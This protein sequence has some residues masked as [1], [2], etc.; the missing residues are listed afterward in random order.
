MK[1]KLL[2]FGLFAM[3]GTGLFA[4]EII[5][6]A[7][8]TELYAKNLDTGVCTRV[9]NCSNCLG[10]SWQKGVTGVQA[11]ITGRTGTIYSFWEDSGCGTTPIYF[12]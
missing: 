8:A 6:R 10:L 12:N 7:W 11:Q 9:V 4:K 5:A 3:F 1:R 2:F